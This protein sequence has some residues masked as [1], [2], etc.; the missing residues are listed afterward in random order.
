MKK[1]QNTQVS[2][3]KKKSWT[4]HLKT[5]LIYGGVGVA[6]FGATLAWNYFTNNQNSET[7]T[8]LTAKNQLEEK[9]KE[10]QAQLKAEEPVREAKEVE[11]D[12]AG[13][14]AMYDLF[15]TTDYSKVPNIK[16]EYVLTV[17]EDNSVVIS[18]QTGT[19]EIPAG[20]TSTYGATD[21]TVEQVN[22][23]TIKILIKAH[24]DSTFSDTLEINIR[25]IDKD[26]SYIAA[27]F[28]ANVITVTSTDGQSLQMIPMVN[29]AVAGFDSTKTAAESY[30]IY[31][32][33]Y[34]EKE[35]AF[36]TNILSIDSD[37]RL[38]DITYGG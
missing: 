10:V 18:S 36:K 17:F 12:K 9:Q 23:E 21:I 16:S 20:K 32:V 25:G 33:S 11:A 35:K 13:E 14:K 28:A 6:L 1:E 19:L 8:E 31:N 34:E 5:I 27:K 7:Q 38:I 24:Y 2:P 15:E 26:D 29:E 37:D 30:G 22:S 4:S 3:E